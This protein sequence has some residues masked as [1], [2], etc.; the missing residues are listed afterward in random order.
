GAVLLRR[1]LCRLLVGLL[2][3]GSVLRSGLVLRRLFSGLVLARLCGLGRRI[4]RLGGRRLLGGSGIVV[5]DAAE[6]QGRAAADREHEQGEAAA[7]GRDQTLLLPA[8]GGRGRGGHLT[9][10]G[11]VGRARELGAGGEVRGA[12]ILG[13][14]GHARHAG[15]HS[16]YGTLT[17]GHGGAGAGA[18]VRRGTGA[19][20]RRVAV[21]RRAPASRPREGRGSCAVVCL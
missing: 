1:G 15:L 5:A 9:G 18:G 2:L 20:A 11:A 13:R 7:S 4:R 21:T 6:D 3:G 8:P 14:R 16:G 17:L 12:R 10:W 19:S